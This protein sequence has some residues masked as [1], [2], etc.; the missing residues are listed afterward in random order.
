MTDEQRIPIQDRALSLVAPRYPGE[1]EVAC[2]IE[3]SAA[4]SLTFRSSGYTEYRWAYCYKCEEV[5]Y[6]NDALEFDLLKA[7]FTGVIPKF[8]DEESLPSRQSEGRR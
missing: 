7:L 2:T 1:P 8:T 6:L 3:L 4:H 5:R